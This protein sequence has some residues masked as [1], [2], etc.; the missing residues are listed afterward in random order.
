MNLD[1]HDKLKHLSSERMILPL[2]RGLCSLNLML[3]KE[4]RRA[5]LLRLYNDDSPL[6]DHSKERFEN[7]ATAPPSEEISDA[8]IEA[9][10]AAEQHEKK[11]VEQA[12][13]DTMLRD[14]DDEGLDGGGVAIDPLARESIVTRPEGEGRDVAM[15]KYG[16]GMGADNPAE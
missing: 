13:N 10:A 2:W 4:D 6:L 9:D 11:Q 1:Q 15:E 14:E 8:E 16:T 7:K 12:R 5:M 3:P